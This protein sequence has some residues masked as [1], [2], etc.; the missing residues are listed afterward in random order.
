MSST[1]WTP[2]SGCWRTGSFRRAT[3]CSRRSV[4][5][6]ESGHALVNQASRSMHDILM[7][8]KRVTELILEITAATGHQTRAIDQVS[9]FIELIDRG[10]TAEHRLGGGAQFRH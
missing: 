3:A 9:P 5:T 1:R 7:Q 2:S 6:V 10:H 8:V 4:N